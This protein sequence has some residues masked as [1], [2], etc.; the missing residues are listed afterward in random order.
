MKPAIPILMAI[1]LS[2]GFVGCGDDAASTNRKMMDLAQEQKKETDALRLEHQKLELEIVEL[3]QG[4][5]AAYTLQGC[6]LGGYPDTPNKGLSRRKIAECDAI[7][8]SQER[9]D[10]RQDAAE[11]RKDAEYDKKHPE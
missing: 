2:V 4:R 6:Y 3:S 1:L 9:I 10:A 7:I 5:L 11:K 8:K